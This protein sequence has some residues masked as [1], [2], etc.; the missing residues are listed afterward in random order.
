MFFIYE[1]EYQYWKKKEEAFGCNSAAQVANVLEEI[2][3]K[4]NKSIKQSIDSGQNPFR[5]IRAR[6]KQVYWPKLE[7]EIMFW[8]SNR[9]KRAA[10]LPVLRFSHTRCPKSVWFFFFHFDSFYM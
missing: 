2:K 9:R 4:K 1:V 7:N 3:P 10:Q 5:Q 8:N 6:E